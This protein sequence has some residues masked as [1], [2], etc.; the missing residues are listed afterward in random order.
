MVVAANHEHL[1]HWDALVKSSRIREC[2]RRMWFRKTIRIQAEKIVPLLA[3]AKVRFVVIGALAINGW[4]EQVRAT[5]DV[6]MLVSRVHHDRVMELLAD[7]FPKLDAR[8]EKF[9]TR[10]VDPANDLPAIDLY[11]PRTPLLRQA[12]RNR[13]CVGNGYWITDFETTLVT[14]F[15]AM[16]SP[17]CKMARRFLHASDLL[18]AAQEH[19]SEIS[20]KKIAELW[21]LES[22]DNRATRFFR[23]ARTGRF[24]DIGDYF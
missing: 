12:L 6:D 15:A 11:R 9:A 13:I 4:R 8:E 10:L 23:A 21:R 7:A 19:K 5:Q 24:F 14:K 2:E 17:G 1:R 20:T 3:D 16:V 22:L 18:D